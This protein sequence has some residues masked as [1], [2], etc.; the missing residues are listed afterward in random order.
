VALPDTSRSRRDEGERTGR[1]N[2]FVIAK[3]C[4]QS[5]EAEPAGS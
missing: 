5:K 3:N 1:K 2:L 4:R